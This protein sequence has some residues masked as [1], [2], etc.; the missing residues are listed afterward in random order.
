MSVLVEAISV[1]IRAEALNTKFPG[2][3]QGFLRSLPNRTLCADGELVRLGFMDPAD[4]EA[5]VKKLQDRGLAFYR[6]GEFVDLAVVQPPQEL[7]ARC[8]WLE[9]ARVPLNGDERQPV[10]AARLAGSALEQLI[11]PTG[12]RYEGSVTQ[13]LEQA[14]DA[15]DVTP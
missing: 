13:Q 6:A 2:G 11:T 4:V 15:G 3:W 5:F 7:K 9:F 10:Y 1:V 8:P 12:W 14:G